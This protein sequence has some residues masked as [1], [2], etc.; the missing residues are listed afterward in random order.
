MQLDVR[1]LWKWIS[2]ARRLGPRGIARL[3]GGWRWRSVLGVAVFGAG[4]SLA[5]VDR[6]PWAVGTDSPVPLPLIAS[7]PT[8][9]RRPGFFRRNFLAQGAAQLLPSLVRVG[10]ATGEQPLGSGAGFVW[11]NRGHVVTSVQV[12]GSR[13]QVAVTLADGRSVM[14]QVLGRDPLTQAALLDLPVADLPPLPLGDAVRLQLG[15]WSL[16]AG[17]PAQLEGSVAAGTLGAVGRV[18]WFTRSL[19]DRLRY[20]RTDA[21]LSAGFVGGPLTDSRG[22]AVGLLVALP[23]A[24]RQWPQPAAP[25]QLAAVPID[26]VR[27]AIDQIL[28]HGTASH[29]YLG[30]VALPLS[31]ATRA[32]VQRSAGPRRPLA[33]QRGAVVVWV[34]PGS[35][36]AAAGL[37]VGEVIV[38]ARSPLNRADPARPALPERAPERPP[39]RAIDEPEQLLVAIDETGVGGAIQLTVWQGQKRVL[40]RVI[41]GSLTNTLPPNSDP[42]G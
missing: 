8:E 42:G 27:R 31:P 17:H 19:G 16:A 25:L 35:P 37:Q 21:A 28:T 33:V 14:A 39:E 29:P 41:L 26:R 1:H 4:A 12:V 13:S 23:Q 36:A 40:R 2:S 9:P 30:A 15:D 20:L 34:E 10:T 38:A 6:A 11:D 22:R 5:F 18:G 24:A 32:L 3:R 7:Q